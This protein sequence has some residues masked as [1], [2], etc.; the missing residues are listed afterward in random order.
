M[1]SSMRNAAIKQSS[2]PIITRVIYK[3]IYYVSNYK[4][5]FLFQDLV[6]QKNENNESL[7]LIEAQDM[8]NSAIKNAIGVTVPVITGL[9]PA[10]VQTVKYTEK[11][12]GLRNSYTVGR[13]ILAS[14]SIDFHTG[15]LL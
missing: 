2:R 1:T 6:R 9:I 7:S 4:F 12:L 11:K 10:V 15:S 3:N 8:Y 14:S 5:P 13:L